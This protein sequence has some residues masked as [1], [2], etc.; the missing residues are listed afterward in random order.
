VG[1]RLTAQG[2][3][4]VDAFAKIHRLDRHQN[5]HLRGDLDHGE[6]LQKLPAKATSVATSLHT[7]SVILAPVPSDN[8]T[9]ASPGPVPNI[10]A[11][12]SSTKAGGAGRSVAVVA[13]R[14]R[15]L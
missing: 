2:R 3:Q 14:F 11:P 8:S 1:Q 6:R 10:G 15:S 12:F 13:S 9:A 4:A 5:P 7:R